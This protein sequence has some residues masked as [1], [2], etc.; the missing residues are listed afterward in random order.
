[1]P[2]A[3]RYGAPIGAR[4][5]WSDEARPSMPGSAGMLPHSVPRRI[6]YACVALLLGIT[7][8]L[9]NG[10]ISANLPQIQGTLGLTPVQG[11]WLSAGYLMTSM[12]ANLLLFKFRQQFGL[13]RFAQFGM[14]AYAAVTLL[15]LFVQTFAMAMVVR[16]VSGFVTSVYS[17]FAVLYMIQALPK[18]YT[19]QA[20]VIGIGLTQLATPIAWQLSPALLDLGEWRVTYLFESGLALIGLAAVNL[21]HLPPSDRVRVYEW[22]DIVTFLLI[23]PALALLAG[24]LAQGRTQWWTERD[25]IAWALIGALVLGTA[26]LIFE[27]GRAHPLLQVRWLGTADMIR[28]VIGAIAIRFLL[29]EQTYGAV[30]LLRQLGMQQ[31]QLQPLYL[32]MLFGML[33]GIA[34]SALTF[35]PKTM[36]P[37]ILGS[38]VLILVAAIMDHDASSMTRP[39]DM[40][41]S[42]TLVAMGTTLFMGP[43]LLTTITR[44][45]T[46]GT[47]YIVSAVVLFSMSQS[48]GGLLGPA[49]L[50]T[51][52]QFREHEY[53]AQINSH[54]DPTDPV[55]ADRLRI[56]SGTYASVITDPALQ[57]ATG[58]AT[59]AQT[60]TREANVRA[61]DDVFL[62]VGLLAV[63][64]LAWSLFHVL[65][66]ARRKRT[67]G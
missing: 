10:L 1:M 31:D 45:L 33:G 39:H 47:E 7:G 24:V 59:L 56:A 40:A 8:G 50:G 57:S 11:Q 36:V 63:I 28:L 42:Q 27:R 58:T 20:L 2:E 9:G 62:L 5:R 18:R 38:V 21:L 4:Y 66:A 3:P 67:T 44:A 29:A 43:L 55:V 37:Q 26:G 34:L 25:W 35:G 51:F 16:L 60:A 19:P 13:R 46:L 49:M 6:G 22:Q 30:G 64:D 23:A 15:H 52:Q 48:L 53:S 61:F 32:D 65:R 12:S 17:S 14:P 54:V 41:L